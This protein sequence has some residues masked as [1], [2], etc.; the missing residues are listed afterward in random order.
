MRQTT[1]SRRIC[2]R[3][4]S[5]FEPNQDGSFRVLCG[6]PTFNGSTAAATAA[7]TLLGNDASA[8]DLRAKHEAWWHDYW[9]RAG[10]IEMTS[11]DGAADYDV[12]EGHAYLVMKDGDTPPS[13][14]RVSGD[15]ATHAKSF[16]T[17]TIGI[18]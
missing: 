12:Q 13:A 11:Q 16:N 5:I 18:P 3:F 10:L 8:G 6:S 4:P 17:G 9:A 7:N 1:P 14:L 15:A 2:A